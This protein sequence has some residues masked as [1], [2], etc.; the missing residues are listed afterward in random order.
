MAK[1]GPQRGGASIEGLRER[2]ARDPLSRAFL[3]LAEEYRKAGRH[4]E[5]IE[6]CLEGLARHPTYHTARISLG[7]TYLEAGRLDEARR[8]LAEVLE[9]APENHLAGKLLAEVQRRTGDV[10][11][12]METY[13]SILRHYPGD[14]EVEALLKDI[15][16]IQG[17]SPAQA[18]TPAQ[19]SA[20]P[21]QQAARSATR[22][23]PAPAAPRPAAP[24]APPPP[25]PPASPAASPRPAIQ[26]PRPL[27]AA[28]P[29]VAEPSLEYGPEDIAPAPAAPGRLPAASE[30]ADALQT[31]TLAE[32]YLRQ[33]LVE[34]AIEVYRAMLR[35]D[36]G[37][38][39]AARRL[40][41][42]TAEPTGP[43]G[44]GEDPGPAPGA[45]EARAAA[46]RLGRWLE[47]IQAGSGGARQA[48]RR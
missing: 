19:G 23:S 48:G 6:I 1:P 40:Q 24:Y 2:M 38:S 30:G 44:A 4:D 10:G 14:R 47:T 35:V 18:S 34:R 9:L 11:A 31:N 32:L 22:P 5:A 33:G 42:L 7:R 17:A 26:A 3:Q 13:R 41:E 29:A 45:G 20:G 36:P 27:I 43:R 39:K 12:A 46:L 15:L 21:G 25:G 28:P 16:E 8:T 37:N